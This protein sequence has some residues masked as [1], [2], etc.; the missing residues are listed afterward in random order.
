M[1]QRLLE[2]ILVSHEFEEACQAGEAS[3]STGTTASSTAEKLGHNFINLSFAH[4]TCF[5]FFQSVSFQTALFENCP[6]IRRENCV[7]FTVF[8][9]CCV[10]SMKCSLEIAGLQT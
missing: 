9:R 4:S 6:S 3:G 1:I 2:L 8:L 7:F 10:N 5:R